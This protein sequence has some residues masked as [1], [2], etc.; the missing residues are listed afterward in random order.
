MR[1]A[2]S[3]TGRG[4]RAGEVAAEAGAAGAARDGFLGDDPRRAAIDAQLRAAE[5][6]A[7]RR[8][9]AVAI[10]HPHDATIA[11]LRAFLPAAQRRGIKLVSIEA[12]AKIN[13]AAARANLALARTR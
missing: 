3:G 9:Y 5:R 11:A 2:D 7:R 8:G 6:L 1:G 12:I 13:A 10:G 4:A